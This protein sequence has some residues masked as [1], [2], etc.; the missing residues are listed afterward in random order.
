[1]V[2]SPPSE[3]AP[4]AKQLVFL[5]IMAT[6]VAV[7]VFLCGVLVGRGVP[8]SRAQ[9]ATAADVFT[10]G[11]A[12]IAG[13]A[14]D[15]PVAE[16]GDPSSA[17]SDLSYFERLNGTEPVEEAAGLRQSDPAES[18]QANLEPAAPS[19][20]P[21]AVA[22]PTPAVPV[23]VLQ[24][25][26]LRERAQAE[27]VA[28]DLVESGYPAFVVAPTDNAPVPVFRVRVGPYEDRAEAEATGQRLEAEERLRPWVIQL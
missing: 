15:A 26:A 5:A 14:S 2:N 3:P 6:V 20:L 18:G 4:S 17:L 7:I 11:S 28:E 24:V 1:M 10:G 27:Q 25:T 23:F 13:G 16:D 12:P 22:A 9:E 21:S 8:L 19:A